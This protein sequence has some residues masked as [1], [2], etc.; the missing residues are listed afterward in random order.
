MACT[1]CILTVAGRAANDLCRLTIEV[2]DDGWTPWRRDVIDPL[3]QRNGGCS[4]SNNQQS[5]SSTL[6]HS[7]ALSKGDTL[8]SPPSSSRPTQMASNQTQLWSE[9]HA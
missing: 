9:P 4:K 6:L 1:E 5:W 8:I 3:G 7:I 2:T